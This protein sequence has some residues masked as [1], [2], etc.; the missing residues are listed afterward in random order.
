MTKCNVAQLDILTT[1]LDQYLPQSH[2]RVEQRSAGRASRAVAMQDGR[3]IK[4]A[5]SIDRAL[6]MHQT[7]LVEGVWC[8]YKACTWRVKSNYTTNTGCA[9]GYDIVL[10]AAIQ[11]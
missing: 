8:F 7:P 10:P 3:A 9:S 6:K 5:Q 4:D 2:L 1:S 11:D